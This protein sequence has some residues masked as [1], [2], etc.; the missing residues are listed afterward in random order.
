MT[1]TYRQGPTEDNR[2]VAETGVVEIAL[3]GFTYR[4]SYTVRAEGNTRKRFTITPDK[5]VIVSFDGRDRGTSIGNSGLD[6]MSEVLLRELV[7]ETPGGVSSG[8]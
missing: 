7:L 3:A 8:Y 2:N 6:L 4:G 5:R 1:I